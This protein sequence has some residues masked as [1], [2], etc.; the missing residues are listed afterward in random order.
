MAGITRRNLLAKSGAGAA[1]AGLLVAAPGVA[2]SRMHGSTHS[3]APQQLTN[4]QPGTVPSVAFV[5]DAAKG[6]VVLMFGERE[7]VRT[8]PALVAY[9]S[10]CCGEA[11]I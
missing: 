4:A 10:R 8:D 11:S 3:Q 7:V 2:I 9:L 6:E 5:R 1:A